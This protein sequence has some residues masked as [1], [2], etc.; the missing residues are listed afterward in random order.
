MGISIKEPCHEDWTKMTS[1][2]KGAF[3]Q[4]CA[5]EVIDFTDK[6]ALEIKQLL[7]QEISRKNQT[8]GRITN[9]QLDQLNDDFFQW[10]N[11]RESFRAIWIFTLVAVFGLSLFSCQN[12]LSR[13]MIH[14]LNSETIHILA[15]DSSQIEL[16]KVDSFDSTQTTDSLKAMDYPPN[17]PII[18]PWEI[19]TYMGIMPWQ[20]LGKQ[21]WITCEVFLGDFT[22]YGSIISEPEAK[23]FLGETPFD[24]FPSPISSPHSPKT[25][26]PIVTPTGEKSPQSSTVMTVGGDKKFDA[27]I[28][29]NPVDITSRLYLRVHELTEMKIHLHAEGETSP[30]RSGN[31][32]FVTGQHEIDLQLYALQKGFF[33]LKLFGTSQVSVLEFEV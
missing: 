16:V 2:A 33:Q 3:C 23:K 6:S 24:P 21:P 30:M 19:V 29:P 9:Y 15:V 28:H 27:F 4:A 17:F 26:S 18:H 25:N 31:S 20:D 11:E 7:A 13:E 22:I 32:T 1:T 10:K 5:K 14:R 12:T 8:C